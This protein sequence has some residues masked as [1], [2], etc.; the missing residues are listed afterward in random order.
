MIPTL[1]RPELLRTCL[2]CLSRQSM[3]DEIEVI[4]VNDGGAIDL[5]PILDSVPALSTRL[6][7]QENRGP[8]SARNHGIR[9]ARG[10]WIAF[11][12]DD[13][14][15]EPGWLAAIDRCLEREG[16]CLVGGCT[17]NLLL[18][19][20]YASASQLIVDLVYDH[21]NRCPKR[22]RFFASNNLAAPRE[23][24]F[25]IGCFDA[26]LRTAEDRELCRRWRDRGWRLV[27]EPQAGVGHAHALGF[28]D[29]L[30]QHF[31]YGKGASR[32][33]SE[34]SMT[35][36][37]AESSFHASLPAAVLRRLRKEPLKRGAQL[38]LLLIVWQAAN[39]AGFLADRTRL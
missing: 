32:Y 12:D 4:V 7:L 13:C 38:A 29:F 30:R 33:H 35:S 20:P 22:A 37:V 31:S 18:S 8:A 27:H 26:G 3:E 19:N 15:P 25:E 24:L 14:R 9:E 1:D 6:L 36:L 28:M 11:T 17:Y 39:L 16:P 34:R 23:Q 10:Q 5:G 21:Y 2:E